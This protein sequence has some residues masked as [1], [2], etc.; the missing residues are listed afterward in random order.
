MLIGE[1]S[2][3]TGLSRHTIRFYEKMKLI[4]VDRKS[5][6]GN[7]YKEY[8]PVIVEK[9]LFINRVKSFDFTLREVGELLRLDEMDAL[10]CK[11]DSVSQLFQSKLNDVDRKIAEL[12][13]IREKMLRA[14]NSCQGN[15][16]DT[17]A[18]S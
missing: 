6:R 8:S 14:R 16:K 3:K 11:V 7:N 5:R 15:C 2:E 9:L 17:L 4:S 10:S 1:L 18:G 13:T 12:T